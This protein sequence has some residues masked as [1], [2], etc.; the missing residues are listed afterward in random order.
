MVSFLVIIALALPF[1]DAR[2]EQ[3]IVLTYHDVVT[4]PEQDRFATSRANFVAHLE[5]LRKND[6]HVVSL[7]DV[8]RAVHDNAPLP[9]NAVLLTF[10]DGLKSYAEFVQ[11]LLEI[12]G[13]PSVISVV[14]G[15]LD[16][17]S[18]PHEYRDHLMK[19]DDLRRVSQSK[20]VTVFSHT[21]D[22]HYGALANP[23][24]NLR[25]ASA[26]RIF[27]PQARNYE[28]E[29]QFRNRVGRDLAWSA[30]RL[31]E[32]LGKR[33]MGIA[34]PY[35]EYD[36]VL[37]EEAR[38]AGFRF[39]FPLGDV[40]AV[41]T[42]DLI[43]PRM[44]VVDD[45]NAE[46]F[47]TDMAA[48][49]NDNAPV[50]FAE[51]QLDAFSGKTP[52]EQEELLSQV[53]DRLQSLH[54]NA[55][56]VSP[57][58]RDATRAFFP[59]ASYPLATEILHRVLHQLRMRLNLK[60]LYLQVPATLE[61]R[62]VREFY[63]ELARLHWFTG[64]VF[65]GNGSE[66][67][68]R[69]A[70]DTVGYYRPGT[71]FGYV[72]KSDPAPGPEFNIRRIGIEQ[73]DAENAAWRDRASQFWISVSGVRDEESAAAVGRRLSER[74]VANYGFMLEIDAGRD[75][76]TGDARIERRASVQ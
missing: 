61:T 18:V 46:R 6:Y 3:F 49:M 38:R 58:T 8:E 17:V 47:A 11:P 42:P 57:L 75:V 55:A 64:V 25:A 44:V 39:Q 65:S 40:P 1:V 73:V 23:Q 54:V 67:N 66:K 32:E 24:G 50:R 72:E 56:I 4:D 70:K 35:G 19:W 2:A 22:L 13:Y 21:H 33:A 15:W 51:V 14:T 62:D 69:V 53:L 36:G 30:K 12:Y 5:Y 10:D 29:A 52:E 71:K 76:A 16:G 26:T 63:T 28:S 74:G 60:R 9:R 68:L 43:M 45:P 37:I 27:D 48:R 41:P 20:L 7:A 59:T 34:W 31:E